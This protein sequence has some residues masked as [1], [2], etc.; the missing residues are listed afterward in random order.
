MT[1]MNFLPWQLYRVWSGVAVTSFQL[2]FAFYL[3]R[4]SC[5][6]Q[7]RKHFPS[8][9][10]NLSWANA[11][12]KALSMSFNQGNLTFQLSTSTKSSLS[13]SPTTKFH[14]GHALLQ[15]RVY[16][17]ALLLWGHFSF[18]FPFIC[19]YNC[20]IG[21]CSSSHSPSRF[22]ETMH[23]SSFFVA[24]VFGLAHPSSSFSLR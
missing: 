9:E 20:T 7:A 21:A 14:P 13:W 22:Q 17:N 1:E 10:H 19:L 6:S 16:L 23:L 2:S 11:C 24:T 4:G 15:V 18:I 12:I 5:F 3:R 8:F